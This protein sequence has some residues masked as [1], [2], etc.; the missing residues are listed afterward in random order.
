MD[1]ECGLHLD[2]DPLGVLNWILALVQQVKL[3]T[4][5]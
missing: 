1:T 4:R 3:G 2:K 5:F